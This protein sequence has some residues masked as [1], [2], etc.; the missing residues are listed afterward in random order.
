MLFG[1]EESITEFL[2]LPNF[3][4]KDLVLSVLFV[5][6][7]KQSRPMYHAPPKNKQNSWQLGRHCWL[8]EFKIQR[9]LSG[10]KDP[11][12]INQKGPLHLGQD[13][14]EPGY[15]PMGDKD[16]NTMPGWYSTLK[17]THHPMSSCFLTV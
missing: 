10:T 3:I 4:F 17:L 11:G 9:T 12:K 14:K 13:L 15:I 2:T 7:T 1:L 5:L 8:L 6:A 16:L